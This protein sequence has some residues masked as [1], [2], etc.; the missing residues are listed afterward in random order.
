[1]PVVDQ[2][3]YACT[4]MRCCVA[5]NVIMAVLQLFEKQSSPADSRQKIMTESAPFV[6]KNDTDLKLQIVFGE[7][8]KVSQLLPNLVSK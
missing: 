5:V 6:I 1:M 4:L 8:Y 2:L 3:K 7:Y